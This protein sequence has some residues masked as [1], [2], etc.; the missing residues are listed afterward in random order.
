MWKIHLCAIWVLLAGA[1]VGSAQ[2]TI[3]EYPITTTPD[4]GPL[5]IT[6]GPDGNLW[7]T[8]YF[9]NTIGRITTGGVITEF[10]LTTT[11]SFPH[12]ITS[13]PDGNLWFTESIG[14][15]IGRITTA[16]VIT[17][18]PITATPGSQPHW[19]TT[20]PDGN[21]W[22]A[23]FRGNKIGKVTLCAAPTITSLSVDPE[24]LWPPNHQ[25]VPA[26]VSAATAGGCGA[27]FCQI[28][29][30]GSS[31]PVEADGDWV[32]TGNLTLNLRAERLGND[33]GRVYTITVQCTD[34]SGNSTTKTVM[35]N[36]VHDQGQ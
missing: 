11:P 22:F 16:G 27:V 8:E 35:V 15:K 30:V 10:P 6:G 14:N 19:I 20:G 17:E 31:E 2:I 36:V 1:V 25:M 23:E 13:G 18:F 9:G 21:L 26:S 29:S 12:Q 28:V 5:G 4:S 34:S 32:I 3:T 7:L 24:V 33:T